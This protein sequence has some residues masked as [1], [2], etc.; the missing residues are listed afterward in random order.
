VNT[1]QKNYHD[2]LERF[3]SAVISSGRDPGEV[4]L[5]VVT[6]G[7]PVE[8]VEQAYNAG[9]RVFGENY[10]QEAL[11]KIDHFQNF[12]DIEWHMIGHI[13]SRKARLVCENFQY[14][15]SLDSLKLARRLD[16]FAGEVNR[17]LPVLLEFNV[18]AEESK[19]GFPA[20]QE[21]KWE[22][23]V[24]HIETI[25][26]LANLEVYGLMT[27]PPLSI[28]QENVRPY[29]EKLR[30]LQSFLRDTLP[31]NEWKELSMGMSADFEVAIDE[32]A[33]IVRIGTAIMGPR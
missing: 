20:W 31:Q 25:I 33:T 28:D 10:V 16:K 14:V 24:P 3:E 15:Q 12:N 6:K 29:F 1:I 19:F 30:E 18:S 21:D 26:S 27:M 22:D 17:R 5:V 23:L 2:V 8:R 9:V 11:R 7:Q 13:Q 4:K 32:G